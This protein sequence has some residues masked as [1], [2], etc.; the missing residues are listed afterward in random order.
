[1]SRLT[2]EI[3]GVINE[4]AADIGEG[5][6]ATIRRQQKSVSP[7]TGAVVSTGPDIVATFRCSPPG[8]IT[9]A[10]SPAG[11]EVDGGKRQLVAPILSLIPQRGDWLDVLGRSSQI[12][13]VEPIAAGDSIAGYLLELAD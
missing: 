7:T 9:R 8:P 12:V 6:E 1:M 5:L 4:L 10:P 3:A 13:R 2:D 11:S